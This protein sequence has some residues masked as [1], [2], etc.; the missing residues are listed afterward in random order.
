[1]TATGAGRRG[2]SVGL[3]LVVVA[4]LAAGVAA[5]AFSSAPPAPGADADDATPASEQSNPFA[6]DGLQDPVAREPA[7]DVGS[8]VAVRIPSL[9]VS[10]ELEDL[11]LGAEGELEAPVD[12]DLAGWYAEG[13]APGDV[14]PAII[15]GHVDSVTGPAVFHRI[16]ELQRGDT[17]EIDT[18][19]GETLA[20]TVTGST[21]SAKSS[22]PTSEVYSN[23]PGPQLRLITCAGEYDRSIG[24]YLDNLVIFATLDG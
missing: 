9:G 20:F 14:G 16:G 21:Q 11:A 1:M 24:H 6:T 22:F 7:Q 8:P 13:V 2:F 5:F 17:I 12:Y 3:V 15:A 4:L 23:V 19:T 10:S 18:S